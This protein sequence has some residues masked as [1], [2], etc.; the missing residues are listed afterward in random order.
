[1]VSFVASVS[2]STIH[3]DNTLG[4]LFIGLVIAALLTGIGCL[5]T[6]I[7]FMSTGKNDHI[8]VRILIAVLWIMDFLTLIFGV[9]GEYFYFVTNYN[10]PTELINLYWAIP[11]YV[12]I[13]TISDSLVRFM[14]IYRI[15]K[16]SQ[17][18]YLGIGLAVFNCVVE[19]G[20]LLQSVKEFQIGK[21]E[22]LYHITW[23]FLWSWITIVII[24]TF[25]A[26][27]MCI[28]LF[29]MK[30]GFRR[31]D[32]QIDVLMRYSLHTGALTSLCAMGMLITYLMMPHNFVYV[33]V[34]LSLP[35]LYHNALLAL[36]N[37][38][39]GLKKKIQNIDTYNSIQFSN[40]TASASRGTPFVNRPLVNFR[41]VEFMEESG[42][43]RHMVESRRCIILRIVL[44]EPTHWAS[45]LLSN[46]SPIE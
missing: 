11:G 25:I 17:K 9:I 40:M 3:Y 33:G 42:A 22:E 1:M 29:Q 26:I 10:N 41:Q 30:T 35:K 20:S 21:F 31:T 34:F 19:A 24:D 6:Y 16:L 18:R 14:F 4:A 37:G 39:E 44:I 46:K 45:I 28:L 27:S 38:R 15:W 2:D 36:L 13:A 32:S 12:V 23:I 5:Q 43:R 8:A 7:Y